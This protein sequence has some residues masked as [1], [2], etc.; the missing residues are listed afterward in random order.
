MRAREIILE[1]KKDITL[2]KYIL[3]LLSKLSGDP[4]VSEELSNHY[5]D[6]AYEPVETLLGDKIVND[7]IRTFEKADPTP[8][9]EYV[10]WLV[11]MY[12]SDSVRR[13]EDIG[14]TIADYL[15]KF[16]RAKVRKQL[17]E[18][19]RDI[20]QFKAI[21]QFYTAVGNIEI[22]D[23]EPVD[24]GQSTVIY[25]DA[26]VR[27]IT[28]LDAAAACYY[29]RGT[30]WCTA[31]RNNNMF[32]IYAKG[33]PLY[34]VIPKKPNYP[35]EKYQLH[36]DTKQFMDEEDH[37]VEIGTLA[38]WYPSLKVALQKVGIQNMVLSLVS[39]DTAMKI[40]E[41]IATGLV[42]VVADVIEQAKVENEIYDEPLSHEFIDSMYN[43]TVDHLTESPN[44]DVHDIIQYALYFLYRE[45]RSVLG[46]L[47]Y[48]YLGD[49]VRN[50]GMELIRNIK[51]KYIKDTQ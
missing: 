9:K 8:H 3:P 4:S 28:P 1:Y 25:D 19:M 46:I 31:A 10:P 6:L 20:N 34:I 48:H 29:G 13:F 49:R 18:W 50:L 39:S 45:V 24:K 16:H 43:L 37:E 27:V 41:E 36:F 30:K 11:R 44:M 23:R 42:K 40:R 51:R 15:E 33:G 26:S 14:S 12:L 22:T 17:P 2:R 21:S 7:V 35:G 47:D 5:N 32:D 38:E